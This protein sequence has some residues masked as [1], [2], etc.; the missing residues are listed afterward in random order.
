MILMWEMKDVGDHQQVFEE[1][2]LQRHERKLVLQRIV[3]GG[4]K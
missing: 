3:T 2:L 4:E 1:I